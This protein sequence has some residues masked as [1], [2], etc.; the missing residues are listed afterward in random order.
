[1]FNAAIL[2]GTIVVN[3]IVLNNL[4][5]YPDAVECPEWIRIGDDIN[6]PEPEIVPVVPLEDQPVSSGAQ[7]L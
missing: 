7:T 5:E 2:N 1:M 4:S 3:I 6:Q